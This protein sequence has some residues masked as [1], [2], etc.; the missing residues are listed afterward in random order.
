[1]PNNGTLHLPFTTIGLHSDVDAPDLDTPSDPP[2]AP[3]TSRSPSPSTTT[4]ISPATSVMTPPSED[5]PA[6]S[7]ENPDE[8]EKDIDDKESSL[9]SLYDG[10]KDTLTSIKDWFGQLFSAEEDNHPTS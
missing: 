7:L 4:A 3:T 8:N 6:E 10:F 2:Q 9:Q 1:M 5:P